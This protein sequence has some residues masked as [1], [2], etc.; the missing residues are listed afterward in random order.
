MIF[1]VDI[2]RGRGIDLAKASKG[3]VWLERSRFDSRE[4]R[5]IQIGSYGVGPAG[6]MAAGPLAL[7]RPKKRAALGLGPR[8]N[9]SDYGCQTHKCPRFISINCLYE[10]AFN[11]ATSWKNDV[12]TTPGSMFKRVMYVSY[13]VRGTNMGQ[14]QLGQQADNYNGATRAETTPVAMSDFRLH[15]RRLCPRAQHRRQGSNDERKSLRGIRLQNIEGAE[16]SGCVFYP[17]L[18]QSSALCRRFHELRRCR[19]QGMEQGSGRPRLHVPRGTT[20]GAQPG[21]RR[22]CPAGRQV[23]QQ[24]QPRRPDPNHQ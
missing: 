14:I 18:D 6:E 22:L 9:M 11:H 19:P 5:H 13:A 17:E 7:R 20:R 2:P 4:G 16:V 1:G 10:G 23:R 21:R 12:G 3:G 24:S 8:I 15:L